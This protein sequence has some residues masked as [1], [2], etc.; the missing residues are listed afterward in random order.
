[1][2]LTSKAAAA[3]AGIGV[4]ARIGSFWATAEAPATPLPPEEV[5]IVAVFVGDIMLDR[6]VARA[7]RGYGVAHLFA[8][9]APLFV[10]SDLRVGNLE[11]AITT[12][13]SIAQRDNTILRFTFEPEVA[14][15]ALRALNLSVVSLANNH[16][17]DFYRAGYDATRTYLAEWGVASFGHPTNVAGELSAALEVG[18]NRFCFVGYHSLYEPDTTSVL[19]EVAQLRPNCYRIAV[20]PHWGE[21]YTH[22]PNKTQVEVAHA[23]IDAGADLVVGA[24]PHV[25]QNFEEYRGKAIFYS[26][27]NFMFDQNFSWET[28]HG[29]ALRVEF[30]KEKT[31]Y[32]V[33]PTSVVYSVAGIAL[34]EDRELIIEL[35]GV[36]TVT[37][38]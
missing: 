17:L 26:L 29:A 3:V 15:Q 18:G 7:A 1:M 22:I 32:T 2:H 35:I 20:M 30:Y 25:V 27:G 33:V 28:Q 12:N 37:L 5:P 13:V 16:T 8:S 36:D 23:F 31:L 24:H 21:E 19:E 14:E 34:G 11:G 38:P 4:L 6:N 10:G 9:T